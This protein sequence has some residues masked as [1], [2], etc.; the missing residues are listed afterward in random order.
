MPSISELRAGDPASL[1]GY[2]LRGRLG[3]G[4]QGVVYLGVDD[5]GTQAAIKWLR[6]HLASDEVAA[7]R[8]VREA[9]A[10]RRVAPFCIA[11]VLGTGVHEQRPYIASEYVDG[12]SL[13]QAVADEGPR[14][15]AA[16]HRLAVGTATA[17]AAIHQ[18]GIV[19]RDFSPANVLLGTEG[20]RVIDF[21]I[22]KALDATSTITSTP[23]GTPAFMAPE[24]ILAH[25]VGPPADLFA[26]AGTMVFAAGG[27]GPFEAETVPA[28]I[29]RVLH[30]A[31]D[32]SHLT[33]P[34]RDLLAACLSKDPA[35]RPPADQV[36]LRLLDHPS[37]TT[38]HHLSAAPDDLHR[39]STA[40]DDVRHPSAAPSGDL[41][42]QAPWHP[43]SSGPPQSPAV[44]HPSGPQQSSIPGTAPG[45]APGTGSPPPGSGPPPPSG[46]PFPFPPPGSGPPP[47]SGRSSGFPPPGSGPPPPS[48]RPDF[49]RSAQ[50]APFHDP[51]YPPPTGTA[52]SPGQ[53]PAWPRS[54]GNRRN[55]LIGAGVAG[56]ALVAAVAIVV[57]TA[58][59]LPIKPQPRPSQT[60]PATA[61]P[62]PV[63]TANLIPV[64]LPDTGATVYESP[65]DP[66]R[67]TT[68]LVKDAKSGAWVYYA[69]DSLTGSFTSYK[70]TWESMLSPNGR[71]L[72][73][74]GKSY[75]D[76]YDTVE[77]TDKMTS[78]RFTVKTSRQPLSAYVQGW[79]RDST[80][81]LVNIGNPVKQL[82][83]STGFA[84]V[85]VTARKATVASLR[86][87]SLKGIRY[88]F[89]Q[90]GT[91]VVAL[92]NDAGQQA[93]RFFDARGLRVR[94]LP[95]VGAG[96]AEAMFSPSG[97]LF[98]TNCPG[99]RNGDNCL[100]DS[101]TGAEVKRVE[102]PCTGLATW[103]DDD[104][105]ACW[106]RPDPSAGGQQIQVI[107]FT[108]EMVRL[109]AD[110]PENATGLD[111]I[112][113]TTR[114]N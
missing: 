111:V 24:Q 98:V 13:Q 17:L 112:Y 79:S 15:E 45:T 23:L 102:S 10:A 52:G 68:Y 4:G 96:I 106:V 64:K 107:D 85:D 9:A 44:G 7:E 66:V 36:I 56:V 110:V 95:N 84:I 92:S 91:G 11:Q 49:G 71:Y 51:A 60:V 80:R 26:W 73:Q 87:G 65:A 75:V 93:L 40:P 16:L 50:P 76:G 114:R 100:Y 27:A 18:A 89:D 86:E 90:D 77:I 78:R 31:P 109:L 14:T 48:A 5:Q 104:H 58:V 12:P 34:L 82:W 59:S 57:V 22:A 113:T 108:G 81:L 103:Y 47:P 19:H 28:I 1:G 38:S 33:G 25:P 69:R 67:L 6:P 32:L 54:T 30:A 2:E 97:K 99:L 41:S 72:A 105:L 62:S 74:R 20:P 61:S 83:Q 88:G 55:W 70:N 101:R 94:R 63:P 35:H 37:T 29:H 42:R 46:R 21:G 53:P 8:F 43:P 39:P 3:E